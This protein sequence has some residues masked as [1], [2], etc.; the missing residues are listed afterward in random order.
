MSAQLWAI[1]TNRE[2]N[3][4]RHVVLIVII[5]DGTHYHNNLYE[6]LKRNGEKFLMMVDTFKLQTIQVAVTII[7]IIIITIMHIE[8][9]ATTAGTE[10]LEKVLEGSLEVILLLV[11]E[12]TR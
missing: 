2:Q 6:V 11:G 8:T 3:Q 12:V 10:E 1:D 5:K 7:T 9:V 4:Q